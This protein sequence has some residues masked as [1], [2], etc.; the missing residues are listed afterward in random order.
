M[1]HISLCSR[2][3]ATVARRGVE[4]DVSVVLSYENQSA[5]NVVGDGSGM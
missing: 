1:C 5:V 4:S 2:F 3:V